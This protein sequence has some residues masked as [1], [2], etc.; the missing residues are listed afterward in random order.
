MVESFPRVLRCKAPVP[1]LPVPVSRLAGHACA[2]NRQAF[3]ASSVCRVHKLSKCCFLSIACSRSSGV[4]DRIF[5]SR[6]TARK[7][8][9]T[10][11]AH[12]RHYRRTLCTGFFVC[13]A[14]KNRLSV[15]CGRCH[16]F[17]REGCCL[18]QDFP[19]AVALAQ[20]TAHQ[21]NRHALFSQAPQPH[22][23]S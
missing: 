19:T 16:C 9:A 8:A 17:Y 23:P 18:H 1:A 15:R 20:T 10:F 14:C 22:P 7:N 5:L 6:H 3:P 2:V 11:D 13:R 21:A 12:K 4:R